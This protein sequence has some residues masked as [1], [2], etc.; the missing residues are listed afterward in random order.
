MDNFTEF[1]KAKLVAFV[2]LD[3]LK[4]FADIDVLR[5]DLDFE[6]SEDVDTWFA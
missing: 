6:S 1:D 4:N 3:G 2:E 5:V